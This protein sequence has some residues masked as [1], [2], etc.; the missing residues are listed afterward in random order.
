VKFFGELKTTAS[1]AEKKVG[2]TWSDPAVGSLD[3]TRSVN[4]AI[5]GSGY[6]PPEAENPASLDVLPARSNAGVGRTL[7]LINLAT[8][9][10]VGNVS[11]TGCTGTGCLDV[12]DG[13]GNL[14]KNAL[15]ADPTVTSDYGSYIAKKA[16]MGDLQGNYYRFDFTSSGLITK[17]TIKV[18]SPRQPVYA[19]SA[20]MW[21]G[22]T[23]QYIFFSTG[24]DMLPTS[25]TSTYGTGTF[26]LYGLRDSAGAITDA[27][28][29]ID[30]GDVSN[31]APENP[32]INDNFNRVVGIPAGERP[33]T[34]PS[35]AG[36]IVF[37]TTSVEGGSPTAATEPGMAS[38]E[39]IFNFY[40]VTYSGSNGYPAAGTTGGTSGKG[41]GKGG[42]GG[43][44]IAPVKTGFGR[45]TAPFVV[46]QHLYFATS[47][48]SGANVEAFG[49]PNDYNNGVGQ[50]GVR[51]LS[52]REIRR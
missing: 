40:A 42:G 23:Q 6:F 10:L 22:S 33:S 5:V 17:N 14:P 27:F 11:G 37:F 8:G 16:Y 28:T 12:G 35:V 29:P 41:K 49:D 31:V 47:T 50:V 13:G 32:D 7:Y 1:L 44:A 43:T 45:A 15:Q 3:A 48:G 52:W 21:V 19:S 51:I 9:K 2:F 20:L 18:T 26:K 25:P 24:S 34:S 36:E 30:L 4:A 39:P 38:A 46:D